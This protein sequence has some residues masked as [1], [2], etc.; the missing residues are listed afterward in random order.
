[1][2]ATRPELRPLAIGE[3][4]DASVKVLKAN[5]RTLFTISA[6]VM[7]PVGLV[8]L[9]VAVMVGPIDTPTTVVDTAGQIDPAV[10]DSLAA[11]LGLLLVTG[12]FAALGSTLVQASSIVA[13]ARV[14][15]GESPDWRQSLASGARRWLPLVV[16]TLISAIASV[17]GLFLCIAPG[18]FL[19]TSWAVAPAAVVAE[20]RGPLAALRRSYQLVKGRFWPV[21]GTVLL[22]YLLYFVVELI[23]DLVFGAVTFLGGGAGGI[24]PGVV[25]SVLVSVVS[26]PFLAVMITILYFDLRVRHEGYD[27][28]VMAGELG[29]GSPPP[30][31][32]PP[33]DP[34]DPFGLGRPG[35][36]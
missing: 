13:I 25:G 34:D 16:A 5:A 31:A 10:L 14:F 1:M 17:L 3:I 19:F 33:R 11:L 23:V 18:V 2:E 30:A 20:R 15:Q 27:L 22:G 6:L 7:V 36:P 29:H 28:E 35:G 21:L 4:I 32:G 8:Q 24:V 9:V 26:L 12:L